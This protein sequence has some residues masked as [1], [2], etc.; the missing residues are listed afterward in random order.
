[1]RPIG[2]PQPTLVT[3]GQQS[4]SLSAK[5]AV[6]QLIAHLRQPQN[7]QDTQGDSGSDTFQLHLQR[8]SELYR[9]ALTAVT[10][11][12]GEE[13][14]AVSGL[15]GEALKSAPEGLLNQSTWREALQAL[16]EAAAHR[17]TNLLLAPFRGR[18]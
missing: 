18:L 12:T 4:S 11:A 6:H 8:G 9:D 2:S 16:G 13:A 1:M 14:E 7:T 3:F 10:K 17:L 15:V 5:D